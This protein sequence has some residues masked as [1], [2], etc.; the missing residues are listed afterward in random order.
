[1]QCN[2]YT[3]QSTI[4]ERKSLL[5]KGISGLRAGKISSPLPLLA[6]ILLPYHSLLL[7]CIISFHSWVL[8]SVH[9]HDL[10]LT[11]NETFVTL[12]LFLLTFF[13]VFT[14][15]QTAS[16]SYLHIIDLPQFASATLTHLPHRLYNQNCSR[17]PVGCLLLYPS[18]NSYSSS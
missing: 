2:H 10:C 11:A 12:L 5:G 9:N 13:S 14:F 17:V 1:M 16:K 4:M 7:P 15:A 6:A 8:P 3:G 18:V